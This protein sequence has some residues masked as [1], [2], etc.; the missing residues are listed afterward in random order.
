MRWTIGLAVIAF[1]MASARADDQADM[2]PEARTELAAAIDDLKTHHMNRATVEWPAVE[3]EAWRR[4]VG[5][6]TAADAYPAIRYVIA[7]LHEK[8]TF[9]EPADYVKA[10]MADRPETYAAKLS[11]QLPEVL[12]LAGGIGYLSVPQHEG[13]AAHDIAYASALYDGLRR[14]ARSH[15]CRFIVDLRRD[16]GGNMFPM[17]AG[18]LPFL[19]SP[20]YGYWDNGDGAYQPWI[21]TWAGHN[22]IDLSHSAVAVLISDFTH[23]AGEFTAMTFEGRANTRVFG[24]PSGGLV[25]AN[26]AFTL[27]DGAHLAV[28][29]GWGTDRLKRPYRVAIVP[30]E[31]TG[32]GQP[33][34]DAAIAWLKKQRC[35]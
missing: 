9:L 30:D 34:L 18:L 27:P 32:E 33:T 31:Q 2:S 35:R 7:Q 16:G 15:T 28:S 4:A 14:F 29:E 6:K 20:P 11:N 5:A 25:T 23:S 3:A 26:V 1:V 22:T 10:I 8:H 13:S 12:P 17:I 24:E 21:V 19:G